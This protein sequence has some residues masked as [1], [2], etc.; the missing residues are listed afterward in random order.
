MIARLSGKIVEKDFQQVVVDTGGVGYQVYVSRLTS[1]SL[2]GPG[3][4]ASLYIHTHVREN[5]L[6]LYGFCN[7]R[8]RA[9]FE[10]LIAISNIGTKMA[11]NILSEFT[12]DAL[13]RVVR[14]R[15][16]A[17]LTSIPG[18]GRKTAERL[19]VELKERLV[20]V[21]GE[22]GDVFPVDGKGVLYG[23]LL[24]ALL[25]LGYTRQ[26]SRL[27]VDHVFSTG[28]SDIPLEEGLKQSLSFLA[29]ARK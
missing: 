22:E 16:L 21:E 4:E 9:C 12:V 17:A 2:G 20:K 1:S 25:H 26:D 29:K 27:A 7:R 18:V 23:E 10:Q 15:D 28:E 13:C 24:S 6:A 8:Q 14:S 11:L 5:A 19:L 3:A